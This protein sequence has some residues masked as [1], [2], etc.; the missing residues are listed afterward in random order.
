[1]KA[2]SGEPGRIDSI[3]LTPAGIPAENQAPQVVLPLGEVVLDQGAALEEQALFTDPDGDDAALTYSLAPGAP[4][5]VSIDSDSGELTGTPT[6]ADVG[7]VTFGVVATDAVGGMAT[8]LVTV[9]VNNV[10]DAPG[11]GDAVI[12]NQVA[13]QGQPFAY[14]LPAGAFTD[15]DLDV[16]GSGEKLT[17]SAT[18]DGGAALPAWLSIDPDTGALTGTPDSAADLSV[19]ITAT[20]AAGESVSAPPIAIE[21]TT[22]VTPAVPVTI[23]AENFTGV[24]HGGQL[25]GQRLQQRLERSADPRDPD[26]RSRARSR[27]SWAG[28]RTSRRAAP[29]GS[30]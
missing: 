14:D 1:M 22:S 3:T 13:L 4:D 20:D 15:I 17:Y 16:A 9:T 18:L 29:T 19:V 6:N 21:V 5:W 8:D 12:E 25:R 23:E 10:N 24:D 11:I 28:S 2:V 7:E 30:A 26:R 27:P